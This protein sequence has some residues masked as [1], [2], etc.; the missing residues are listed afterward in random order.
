MRPPSYGILS[1]A[2]QD[3]KPVEAP[4]GSMTTL[5]RPLEGDSGGIRTHGQ[6]LKRPAFCEEK[7]EV[8]C[9]RVAI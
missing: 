5:K 8:G 7:E 4:A 1:A 9:C 2:Y 3:I 6:W